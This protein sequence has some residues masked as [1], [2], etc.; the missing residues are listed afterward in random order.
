MSN[1]ESGSKT[2]D[3]ASQARTE[4]EVK[5][6]TADMLVDDSIHPENEIVGLRLL[7]IHIAVTLAAF[8]A[9]LVSIT[10]R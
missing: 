2:A 8:L 1:K 9:G 4:D 10:D 6:D 7:L 5:A 3:E